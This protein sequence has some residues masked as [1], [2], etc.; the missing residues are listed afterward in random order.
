M[1]EEIRQKMWRALPFVGAIL[2]ATL[3]PTGVWALFG[4]GLRS[5]SGAPIVQN[6]EIRVYRGVAYTGTLRAVEG[7]GL[8]FRIETPPKKGTLEFGEEGVFVYTPDANALGGDRFTYSAMDAEGRVSAP[9]TVKIR[10][11]RVS[12]GVRYADTEGEDC[13]TAAVDLAEHGVFVGARMG[14]QW[15]FEPERS[16]SR[17]EFV[18]MTMAAMGV[19]PSEVTVTGFADDA[20]IPTWAKGCAAGALAA[21]A[22]RGV[23]TA[24]GVVFRAERK[25]TRSEAAAVL[26]RVLDV[27][28]VALSDEE[29]DEAAWYAQAVA[30]LESVRIAPAGG[31]GAPERALDRGEA[32]CLLSAAIALQEA[33]AERDGFLS[34]ILADRK[35]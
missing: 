14:D 6:M 4:E 8:T 1:N 2:L 19:A 28:D 23:Q 35:A 27:T 10:I 26:N 16:V 12:S 33:R 13:A 30:N 9:G 32:A 34:R 25:V 31:F 17:G 5:E 22:V 11:S 15:F 21:G 3:L 18:A 7:E 24:E 20:S 29:G